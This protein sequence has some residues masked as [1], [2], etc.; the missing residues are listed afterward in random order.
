MKFYEIQLGIPDRETQVLYK[1]KQY[2][3]LSDAV[4]DLKKLLETVQQ[5]QSLISDDLAAVIARRVKRKGK[6]DETDAIMQMILGLDEDTGDFCYEGIYFLSKCSDF[7]GMI[8]IGEKQSSWIGDY[9][10]RI[11]GGKQSELCF[12]SDLEMI[13]ES[14]RDLRSDREQIRNRLMTV[15]HKNEDG[16]REMIAQLLY[17]VNR[18]GSL[19]LQSRIDIDAGQPDGQ[20]LLDFVNSEQNIEKA[21]DLVPQADPRAEDGVEDIEAIQV[22]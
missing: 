15:W 1:D 9:S 2:T 4:N 10:V 7:E 5:D 14:I 18:D 19:R 13:L 17:T 11:E 8:L 12:F 16:K 22:G 20:M 3:R 21:E 6:E